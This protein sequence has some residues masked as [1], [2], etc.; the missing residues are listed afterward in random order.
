VLHI[1]AADVELA[2]IERVRKLPDHPAEWSVYSATKAAVRY[3]ARTWTTDLKDRCIR[4]NA[5]SPGYTDTP[6]WHAIEGAEGLIKTISK[7][8]PFRKFKNV[9]SRR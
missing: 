6:R 2:E 1:P 3:F 4:V 5:V 9:N 7:T 8:V